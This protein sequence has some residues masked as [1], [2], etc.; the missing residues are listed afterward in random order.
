[1]TLLRDLSLCWSSLFSLFLFMILFQSRYPKKRTDILTLS[2]M[3]P[4]MLTNLILLFF[5]GPEKM[6]TL[7]LVTC[8]LP[9][10][11]F[12]W[13]LAKHRDGRFFFT[14]CFA[15]TMVM[16]LIYV[17][18]ILDHAFG[19]S[20]YFLFFARLIGCPLLAWATF[21]FIRPTYLDVQ[22]KVTKGWYPFAAISFIFYVVLALSMSYPTKITERPEYLPAFI[23]L[24]ILM[25][26]LYMYIFMTLR[27]QQRMHELDQQDKILRLQMLNMTSRIQE[28]SSAEEQFRIDRHNYRHMLHTILGLA[29]KGHHD[30]LRQVVQEYAETFQD[31]NIVRYSDHPVVDAVLG[32]YMKKAHNSKIETSIN[33]DFP[34]VLPVSELE[35]ATVLANA[36]ENAINACEKLPTE[37]RCIGIKV[38]SSP[39]LM[40]QIRNSFDGEV[41]FDK[42]GLPVNRAEGHGFGT[43]SIVS[44][45]KK[46]NAFY[47][48]KS[49][50]N[51]FTLR[52]VCSDN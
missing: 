32:V 8:S 27:S 5:V 36:I 30:Q 1:M 7:L 49:T 18:S 46:N 41:E 33:I 29:D 22:E 52:I 6:N 9:S 51:T 42:D 4:L 21:R 25:P 20:F 31:P 50:A 45:C 44:F 47:E 37:R 13:L 15:D 24:L 40:F 23:L 2:L 48:Y 38:L 34:D 14:F 19:D 12:F 11:V 16:E 39:Q 17:T 35:L 43:L 10:L 28:F 3:G 26:V